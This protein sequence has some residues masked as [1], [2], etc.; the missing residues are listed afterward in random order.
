MLVGE[1]ESFLG[2]LVFARESSSEQRRVVSVERD[3]DALVEIVFR[4]MLG[5]S[6][7]NTGAEVAGDAKFDWNLALGE[8]FDQVGVLAGGKGVANALGAQVERSPYRFRRSGL[9]GVGGQ[10]QSVVCGVGVD[11]AEKLGR[12]FHFVTANAD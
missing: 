11:A 6:L 10:A 1:S 3:H 2:K 4:G 7:A 8:F 5:H 12:S 9:A